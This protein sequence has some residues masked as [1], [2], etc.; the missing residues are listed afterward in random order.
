LL[1]STHY[2]Q[3]FNFTFEGLE[4][5][6]AAVDRLRNFVR[7]LH[8]TDGK[9]SK[10]KVAFLASKLEAD[11][12]GPM[13]N[14]LEISVAL[15]SLFDFVREV[16][17]LL[18][19]NM[20]SKAE[21]AEV[22]GLIMQIDAVLGVIGEV[23]AQEVLPAEIDTLV[24][25]REEARKAKNWKEADAIRTQLKAMGIVLEDTAQGVRWHKEKA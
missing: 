20:V 1:L 11:F 3:Q 9:D 18:D 10:G 4:A 17:N 25:K 24:K 23:K 6:K 13:D 7:R 19:A 16:N 14:D 12:G 8:D 22:G 15:A 21:A 5:A 2:R